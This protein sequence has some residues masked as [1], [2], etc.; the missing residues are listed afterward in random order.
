M[1]F[2]GPAP[3]FGCKPETALREKRKKKKVE[4]LVLW[5][6]KLSGHP[7]LEHGVQAVPLLARLSAYAVVGFGGGGEEVGPRTWT[8][9]THAGDTDRVCGP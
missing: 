4:R 3:C 8:P 1:G 7:Q 6:A 2:S 9:A 5:H